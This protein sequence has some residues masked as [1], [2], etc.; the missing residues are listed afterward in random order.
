[1]GVAFL[2]K[3]VSTGCTHTHTFDGLLY[4]FLNIYYVLLISN[5]WIKVGQYTSSEWMKALNILLHN[6]QVVLIDMTFHP[7]PI[8]LFM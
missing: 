5:A 4:H 6:I 3:L 2:S 1:M 8:H 7:W